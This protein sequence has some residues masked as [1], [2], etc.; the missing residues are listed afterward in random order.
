MFRRRRQLSHPDFS[1]PL[2][3]EINLWNIIPQVSSLNVVTGLSTVSADTQSQL[4]AVG[5]IKG[6]I[7]VYDEHF[8]ESILAV[9]NG[10][11]VKILQ[12]ARPREH[13]KLLCFDNDNVLH[14]WN[15]DVYGSPTLQ[16]SHP[17]DTP[18]FR[19]S[20]CSSHAHAL[21]AT[22][23]GAVNVFDIIHLR[24]SSYQIP[25]TLDNRPKSAALDVS[26]LPDKL[27]Y[28]LIGYTDGVVLC[29]M[30]SRTKAKSF[31]RNY[32]VTGKSAAFMTLS[33]HPTGH[34]FSAGYEDGFVSVWDLNDSKQVWTGTAD[35]KIHQVTEADGFQTQ[36]EPIFKMDW[37]YSEGREGISKSWLVILGGQTLSG[38]Q[39]DG[40]TVLEFDST[41]FN[42]GS[43]N[44]ACRSYVYPST[45]PVQDFSIVLDAKDR[46]S[47]RILLI[48]GD[49]NRAASIDAFDF[50]PTVSE[51]YLSQEDKTV[52]L[53]FV[54]E[55]E[56]SEERSRDLDSTLEEF[57]TGLEDLD[58]SSR[59]TVSLKHLP[60]PYPLSYSGVTSNIKAEMVSLDQEEYMSLVGKPVS[61]S[62]T[63]FRLM[64]TYHI[65]SS[66]RFY[67]LS[68][69]RN[70]NLCRHPY[71]LDH[72]TIYILEIPEIALRPDIGTIHITDIIF[73]R[74]SL[75][76]I[77]QLSTGELVVFGL[78]IRQRT[79]DVLDDELVDISDVRDLGQ[80]FSSR[81]ILKPQRGD[82]AIVCISDIGFL[83]V[84]YQY[85]YIVVVD[86]R[87]PRIILR[88][89]PGG[90]YLKS[91]PEN[92][93]KSLNWIISGIGDDH[94]PR[95][96]LVAVKSDGSILI[97][98][99]TREE[100]TWIIDTP[101]T[102]HHTHHTFLADSD[103][104]MSVV[105]DSQTGKDCHAVPSNLAKI[106][107]HDIVDMPPTNIHCYWIVAN[108]REIRV[109]A[110]ITGDKVF[111][112]SLSSQEAIDF[113]N[114]VYA[115]GS[116]VLCSISRDSIVIY[117]LPALEALHSFKLPVLLQPRSFLSWTTAGD[118]LQTNS[119]GTGMTLTFIHLLSQSN[120]SHS[121]AVNFRLYKNTISENTVNKS[122]VPAANNTWGTAFTGWIKGLGQSTTFTGDDIDL[123]LTD[124]RPEENVL[125][126][127]LRPEKQ[128]QILAGAA[129]SLSTWGPEVYRQM[130]AAAAERGERLGELQEHFQQ[131]E[132]GSRDL[133]TQ[134]K[135]MAE[136]QAAKSW[137]QF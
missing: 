66:V 33:L 133:A 86:M 116:V 97:Y 9:P 77:V 27:N 109:Y 38:P 96:R 64:I 80:I 15:L 14:M 60:L 99:L 112:V 26:I 22:A 111:K 128:G 91:A 126:S 137:F 53:D 94:I 130:S 13:F 1:T 55:L 29:D 74:K 32:N 105:L 40:V 25:Y 23:S 61:D 98:T 4:F 10:S 19:I 62:D 46:I 45:Q 106:L 102:I 101:H 124:Q 90:S 131:L 41:H 100:G 58:E 118:G 69:T 7:R 125:P 121:G 123:I 134:A 50:L 108:W 113:L 122:Q 120:S 31:I 51:G 135:R 30:T 78:G 127:T 49:G 24:H 12:F 44:T 82:P 85:D 68:L 3:N 76:C 65:D 21:L 39:M 71:L 35:G 17:F 6:E 70:L 59:T 136:K 16:G 34:Y 129:A 8:R 2:R 5:T 73:A 114:P 47:R 119:V 117:S 95:P 37:I 18:I 36:R 28:V 115:H 93:I 11:A 83:A 110:N 56:E 104:I 54:T 87:G 67:D 42:A 92:T 81:F 79:Q 72:L 107:E 88:E 52:E 57:K 48:S 43:S 63:I 75:E 89:M 103:P 132:V 84:A 20:T